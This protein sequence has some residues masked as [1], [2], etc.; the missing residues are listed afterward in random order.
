MDDI[1]QQSLLDKLKAS[2]FE[3]RTPRPSEPPLPLAAKLVR[4]R[5]M[6][7]SDPALFLEKFGALLGRDE[8]NYFA[9]L[10]TDYEVNHWATHYTTVLK[11]RSIFADGEDCGVD[12]GLSKAKIRNRRL[13]YLTHV[14][15]PGGNYYS[16]EEMKERSPDLF[17]QYVGQFQ[18]QSA[19]SRDFMKRL[20]ARQQQQQ[21]SVKDDGLPPVANT[22]DGVVE[23]DTD[24]E[25]APKNRPKDW[26]ATP[27]TPV[28]ETTASRGERPPRFATELAEAESSN[29]GTPRIVPYDFI[30][31]DTSK[32]LDGLSSKLPSAVEKK[33]LRDELIRLLQENFLDG[34][35]IEFAYAEVDRNEDYDDWKKTNEDILEDYFDH[36]ETD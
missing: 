4:A 2:E 19:S 12:G 24:D 27:Y 23:Y 26:H 10:T 31:D 25:D 8:L 11:M 36:D 6:L 3:V 35:D 14:L 16:D 22:D 21:P 18:R 30:P 33:E 20:R 32:L 9:A 34:R 28:G 15:V 7:E 5:E 1:V 17:Q 13:Y 29:N